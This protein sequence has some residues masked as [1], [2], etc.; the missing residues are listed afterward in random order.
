MSNRYYKIY[1]TNANLCICGEIDMSLCEFYK[2]FTESS[3]DLV[4]LGDSIINRNHIV[5]IHIFNEKPTD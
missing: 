1:S 3:H 5:S 2:I 4:N